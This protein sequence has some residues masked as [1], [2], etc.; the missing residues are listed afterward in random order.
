M[1]FFN[2]LSIKCYHLSKSNK[3]EYIKSNG[4]HGF[5]YDQCCLSR[6]D[7]NVQ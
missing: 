2:T 1:H 6:M 3:V 4:Q 5:A 7:D